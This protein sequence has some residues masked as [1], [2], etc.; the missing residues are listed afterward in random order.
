MLFEILDGKVTRMVT[1]IDRER[2]FAELGL[3]AEVDGR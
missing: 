2:A 3:A 1:Y